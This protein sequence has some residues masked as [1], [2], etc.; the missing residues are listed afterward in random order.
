MHYDVVVELE[1]K[2]VRIRENPEQNPNGLKL[3][4]C[5]FADDNGNKVF[6]IH[7]SVPSDK[8]LPFEEGDL[9]RI[10]CDFR[11]SEVAYVGIPLDDKAL[12]EA[13]GTEW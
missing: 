13:A 6:N 2:C 4:I 3:F 10:I 7:R 9:C 11:Q 1:L 5:D 8:S 12:D